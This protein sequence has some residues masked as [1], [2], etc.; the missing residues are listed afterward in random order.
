MYEGTEYEFVRNIPELTEDYGKDELS[1]RS[2]KF[3]G[4]GTDTDGNGV[5]YLL[6]DPRGSGK[7]SEIEFELDK[8]NEYN[9]DEY[10]DISFDMYVPNAAATVNVGFIDSY[11]NKGSVLKLTYGL[12]KGLFFAELP[13]IDFRTG[14]YDDIPASL[15]FNNNSEETAIRNG[16]HVDLFLKPYAGKL[17]TSISNNSNDEEPLVL[18]SDLTQSTPPRAGY[19]DTLVVFYESRFKLKGLTFSVRFGENSKDI[20]FDNLVTNIVKKA[21]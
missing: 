12:E 5:M 18:T 21:D 6:R 16:A 17:I 7:T 19:T 4:Y 1:Y 3:R 9:K 20:I 8:F 10:I 14:K 2:D 15:Y 11:K 13:A